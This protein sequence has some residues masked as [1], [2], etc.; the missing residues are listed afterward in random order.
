M[1][2]YVN[3]LDMANE[4]ESEA[5]AAP[6]ITGDIFPEVTRALS[7]MVCAGTDDRRIGLFRSLSGAVV[8]VF[9]PAGSFHPSSI[10]E[11]MIPVSAFY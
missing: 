7:K 1:V 2:T 9:P 5:T 6:L 4:D 8:F 10:D 11:T 3:A